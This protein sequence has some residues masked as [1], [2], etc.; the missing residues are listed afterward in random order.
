VHL[1]AADARQRP[2]SVTTTQTTIS[3]AAGASPM[4]ASIASK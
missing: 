3:F 2:L 4:R 1:Q